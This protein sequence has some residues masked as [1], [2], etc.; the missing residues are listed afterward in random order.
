MDDAS[1]KETNNGDDD[2]QSPPVPRRP[3]GCPP[4]KKMTTGLPT[5]RSDRIADRDGHPKVLSSKVEEDHIKEP[6]T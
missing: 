3:R 4:G 1:P 5:H 6:D 2:M